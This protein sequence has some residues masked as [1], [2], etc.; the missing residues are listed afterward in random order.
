MRINPYVVLSISTCIQ[1]FLKTHIFRQKI[2]D[3]TT[4]LHG[5]LGE[6]VLCQQPVG[7]IDD[8]QPDTVCLLSK[9]I[10]GLKQ[11]PRAWYLR[12]ANFITSIGF[13]ATRSDTSLFV[14]QRGNDVAYLLLYVDDMVLTASSDALLRQLIDRLQR[15][16][17][18]KDHAAPLRFFLSIDVHLSSSGFFLSQSQYAKDLLESAG[19]ANCKSISTPVDTNPKLSS[20]SGDKLQDPSNYRSLAGALQYLTVTRP[21]IT[22]AVQQ[23]CLHMHDPQDCHMELIKRVLRYVHST[24]AQGLHLRASTSTDTVAYSDADWVGC[25]DTRQSTSGYC[26]FIGDSL[27]SWSSKRQPVVS[28]SSA[29]VSRSSAEAEYRAE[30]NAVAECTWLRQLLGEFGHPMCKATIVYCDNVSAVY[31]ASNPVHHR[32]TKHIELDIHFVREK[33]ALGDVRVFHVPTGQQYADVLTKGLPTAVFQEFKT[34][35]CVGSKD[36]AEPAAGC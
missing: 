4:F 3:V 21:D 28:R 6:R 24:T 29:E 32:R 10:Y 22:Y 14:L 16:F 25:P 19:M 20:S 5:H 36:D 23:I 33:V 18:L 7:F 30:A 31:M 15:E 11:A 9:S 2:R 27:V 1:K 13:R 17:A 35:L 34:S 12:F 8:Q 26:V